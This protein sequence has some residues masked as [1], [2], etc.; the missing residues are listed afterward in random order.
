VC[1]EE[2]AIRNVVKK[3]YFTPSL[4]LSYLSPYPNEKKKRENSLIEKNINIAK[5]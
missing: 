2:L 5:L 1:S 4:Y 3:N